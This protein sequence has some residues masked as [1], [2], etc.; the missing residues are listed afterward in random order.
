MDREAFLELLRTA[1]AFREEVRRQLLTDDVLAL[2]GRLASLTESVGQIF[3]LLREIV[4]V[5]R[6]L[7]AAQQRTEVQMQLL[8]VAQQRTEG[9][10]Q[11][12]TV[13]Q[14]HTA[15]ELQWLVSWQ[16]G[17]SGRRDGE[18][19]ER[20]TLRRAPAL[21]NGGRGGVPDQPW[22]QQ[23]LTERLDTLMASG[24]FEAEEDPFLADLLWWK[25]EQVAVT[26]LSL[27]VDGHDV[28]RA[29]RRAGTLRRA[30]IQALAVVIGENWATPEVRE[31][32]QA[33]QVAWKVGADLSEDFLTFRRA[34]S[35]APG[36]VR[37]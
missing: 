27:Q 8:T 16:R 19:Y 35:E 28:V 7:A 34:S 20:E 33:R 9:Q 31:Q 12:L 13:A 21:F 24:M 23:R 2:P 14:Q 18:R 25:G 17:A 37:D 6:D 1:P 10:M 3:P 26:E 32:A 29:V 15:E 5:V 22:V 11:S 4:G 36:A 30:G